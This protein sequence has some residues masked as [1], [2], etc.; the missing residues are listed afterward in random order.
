M[1]L[2]FDNYTAKITLSYCLSFILKC[3]FVFYN[4]KKITQK[5]CR[6]FVL[7]IFLQVS[8]SVSHAGET[9]VQFIVKAGAGLV[10][11]FRVKLYKYIDRHININLLFLLRKIA[12][13]YPHKCLF[14]FVEQKRIDRQEFFKEYS[15]HKR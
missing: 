15:C 8:H 9:Y 2:F 11:S 7:F 10:V 6:K 1:K 12:L 4:L 3:L 13:P 5:F 14:G